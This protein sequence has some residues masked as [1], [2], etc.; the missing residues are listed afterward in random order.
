M[1]EERGSL[2]CRV[3]AQRYEEGGRLRYERYGGSVWW[4]TMNRI[5]QGVGMDDKA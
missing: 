1:L 5:R 3:L 2:W 4:Q